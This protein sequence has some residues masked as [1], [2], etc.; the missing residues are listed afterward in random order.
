MSTSGLVVTEI[1][2]TCYV[3]LNV[4]YNR[5]DREWFAFYTERDTGYSIGESWNGLTR[6][7]VLICRPPTPTTRANGW[8][9]RED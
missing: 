2:V 3:S 8:P 7:E 9:F 4:Y 6:D 5:P 1:P